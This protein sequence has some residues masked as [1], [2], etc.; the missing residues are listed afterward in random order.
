MVDYEEV[1]GSLDNSSMF[2]EASGHRIFFNVG[3]GEAEE[4]GY[5]HIGKSG[6]TGFTYHCVVND[7]NLVETTMEVATHAE[8]VFEAKIVETAFTPDEF[9]PSEQIAWYVVR[10]TRTEDKVETSVHRFVVTNL[11]LL[12]FY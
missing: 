11:S 1:P 4:P 7:V 5:F 3:R 10:A 2:M 8:I 9:T 12:Q 6:W